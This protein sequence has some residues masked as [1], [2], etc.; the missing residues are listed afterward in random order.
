M[1]KKIN[2]PDTRV[3]GKHMDANVV[4]LTG[5]ISSNLKKDIDA[6]CH[7]HGISNSEFIRIAA[8]TFLQNK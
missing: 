8:N 4:C 7:E 6:Y 3:I 5:K 2:Y 1:K